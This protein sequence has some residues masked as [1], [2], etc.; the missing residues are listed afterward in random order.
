M[1][2]S[3]TIKNKVVRFSYFR[4]CGLAVLCEGGHQISQQSKVN[5]SKVRD[6]KG[7]CGFVFSLSILWY[8]ILSTLSES[9]A[10][11]AL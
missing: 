3:T 6:G 10:S 2:I 11:Y 9:T 5:R 7:Y 1:E 4:V 8:E